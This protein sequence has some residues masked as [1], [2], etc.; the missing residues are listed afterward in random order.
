[1]LANNLGFAS[2]CYLPGIDIPFLT[3]FEVEGFRWYV[4][5]CNALNFVGDCGKL[6]TGSVC[7]NCKVTL[8]LTYNEPRPGVRRA[9]IEDFKPP[10][11]MATYLTPSDV[12]TFSIRE[13]SA[14]VTRLCLLL[15]S[16][17]LMNAA[18]N[19]LTSDKAI[20]QLLQTLEVMERPNHQ[21]LKAGE[22]RCFLIRFLS[23]HIQVHLR[24][25]SHILIVE[26][27][28]LNQQDQFRVGYFLLHQFL[29]FDQEAL[30]VDAAQYA[31]VPQ[32]R[33]TFENAL[34]QFL[35]Q[36]GPNLEQELIRV[37]QLSNE[38]SRVFGQALKN[39][40]SSH[41]AYTW[42]VSSNRMHVQLLLA[43]DE[44]LKQRYP[45][46]NLLLDENESTKLDALQHFGN[47]VRFLALA[48]T[49]LQESITL[50]DAMQM[51]IGQGLEKMAEI[52]EKKSILLDRGRAV[53][54]RENVHHLFE[55]FKF[56]WDRF[57][58]IP[59]LGRQTFLDYIQ[60]QGIANN[61]RPETILDV[62]SPLLL[63]LA[64]TDPNLPEMT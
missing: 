13:K 18:M 43:R 55:G 60:C 57:S 37:T 5:S 11:G 50:N 35:K 30:K 6:T 27:P 8:A 48:R 21:E 28:H 62:N 44:R 59:N 7:T 40:K 3:S 33:E 32:A 53:S 1:M 29:N 15:N 12:P 26:R 9:T 31:A 52:V 51:T 17:V 25:L 23:D 46:L 41:W 42:L 10:K 24:I 47:A 61:F 54:S 2:Q 20:Y 64:V 63:V 39:N 22:D 14:A 19:P 4:C 16:L 49:I 58:Q 34:A 36:Q 45:F 56:L 38:T